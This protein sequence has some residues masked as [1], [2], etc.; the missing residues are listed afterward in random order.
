MKSN[1]LL[2]TV[3]GLA[4]GATL[5]VLFAPDKGEKTRKKIADKSLEAKDHLKD[6]LDEFIETASDKYASIKE[7]GESLIKSTKENLIKKV[8]SA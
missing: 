2:A 7:E 5:G 4:V 8:K 1:S 6:N 3:A